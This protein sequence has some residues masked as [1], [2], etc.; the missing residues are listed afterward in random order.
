MK[1]AAGKRIP[2]AEKTGLPAEAMASENWEGGIAERMR[3]LPRVS[4][5]LAESLER[6]SESREIIRE[7]PR[8]PEKTRRRSDLQDQRPRD[9]RAPR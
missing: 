8:H 4:I 7:S 1:I 9:P 5:Q 3:K 6:T 2:R